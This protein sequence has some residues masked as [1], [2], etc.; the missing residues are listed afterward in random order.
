MSLALTL[1]A[2]PVAYSLFDDVT[3]W[4]KKRFGASDA[5]DR[6][7]RELDDLFAGRVNHAQPPAPSGPHGAEL[8]PDERSQARPIPGA[9]RTEPA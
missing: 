5:V 8:G 1:L 6:G 3:V 4:M 7:E 2:T 9:A